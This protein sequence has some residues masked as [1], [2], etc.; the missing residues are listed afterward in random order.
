MYFGS[1][2][3]TVSHYTAR[4]NDTVK[5]GR[6]GGSRKNPGR[7]G[8]MLKGTRRQRKGEKFNGSYF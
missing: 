2:Q 6:E 1:V 4:V 7:V 8:E 3:W 5:K